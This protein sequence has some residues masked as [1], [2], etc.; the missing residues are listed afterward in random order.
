[1]PDG[2]SIPIV[3]EFVIAIPAEVTRDNVDTS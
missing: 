3:L 1:M 2:L